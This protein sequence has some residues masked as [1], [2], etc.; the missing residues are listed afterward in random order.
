VCHASSLE[1]SSLEEVFFVR[2]V[3]TFFLD[4]GAAGWSGIFVSSSGGSLTN[5]ANMP[6]DVGGT[7]PFSLHH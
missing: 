7:S 2:F 1:E 6:G 4:N 5:K 3:F